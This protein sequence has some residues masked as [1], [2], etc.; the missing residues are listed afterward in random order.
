MASGIPG[1]DH[2]TG[3]GL[4]AGEVTLLAGATGVGK[5]VLA[6]QFLAVGITGHGEPGV[7]VSLAEAPGKVR[8]FMATFGWDVA[9]WEA[10]DTW[11]FVDGSPS[12]EH[13][14]VVGDNFDFTPLVARVAAAV[15]QIGAKRVVFD[16]LS[17]LLFR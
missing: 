9:A 15:H 5:T 4:P 13:E 2:V 11:E 14:I 6:G 7:F 17:H 10:A 12:G 16:S 3:G 8:R 1:L